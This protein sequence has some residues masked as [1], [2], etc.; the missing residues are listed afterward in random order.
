MIHNRVLDS[1]GMGSS[2]MIKQP[3]FGQGN[4]VAPLR[5]VEP[6][7]FAPRFGLA[8]AQPPND[9][10]GPKQGGMLQKL[11]DK[12]DNLAKQLAT[13]TQ[14]NTALE[15][16]VSSLRKQ[17]ELQTIA[18]K[19]MPSTVSIRLMGK[20]SLTQAAADKLDMLGGPQLRQQ[21]EAQLSKSSPAGFG[22]GFWVMC[23]DGKPRIITNAHVV[24]GL[25]SGKTQIQTPFGVLEAQL[26]SQGF[27]GLLNYIKTQS[28]AE[29]AKS[30]DTTDLKVATIPGT[31][32]QAISDPET[33][34]DLAVL[35]PTDP[36]FQLPA[37]ITPAQLE[38]DIHKNKPGQRVFKI[39]NSMGQEG[40][41]ADG[42]ISSFKQDRVN[43][44][45]PKD[46]VV[47]E[48]TAMLNPGD[49]GGA[50]FNMDGKVI[51]INNYIVPS[52]PDGRI[53]MQGLGYSI[54]APTIQK[55]LKG[56][57]FLG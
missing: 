27:K 45:R 31:N 15:T 4:P 23:K 17:T 9:K 19:V 12:I 20:I 3:A 35:E 16:E 29:A 22:S 28:T 26:T 52:S 5:L 36:N 8:P 13:L 14:K 53:P 7:G 49:S 32:N 54:G 24:K 39:G 40:N 57:G 51:G 30:A 21:V 10:C 47:L 11:L 1:I 41:L 37:G 2:G 33:G 43:K 48:N 42:V 50:L 44:K 34:Y 56:W 18:D 46:I 25:T 55:V 6:D 38:T